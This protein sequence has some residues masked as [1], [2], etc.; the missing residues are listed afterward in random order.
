[1][2]GLTKKGN[3][4]SKETP[5]FSGMVFL[6][7]RVFVFGGYTEYGGHGLVW[8]AFWGFAF[9]ALFVVVWCGLTHMGSLVCVGLFAVLR[10]GGLGN[11]SHHPERQTKK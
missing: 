5:G 4:I 6:G 8:F 1:M 7:V 9:L 10:G 11:R 3:G 2:G